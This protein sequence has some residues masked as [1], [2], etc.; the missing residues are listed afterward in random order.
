LPRKRRFTTEIQQANFLAAF[1]LVPNVRL[2]AKAANI[3]PYAHYDWMQ[4]YPDYKQKW[5]E[6]V[7]DLAQALEDE[8]IRRAKDG[9]KRML[10]Y[11]G[12]PIKTGRGKSARTAYET[13]Y[14]DQ[15]L[16]ALLK[17]FRPA[18]YREHTSVD[19]TG[20]IDL[21]ERMQA[22][23]RRVVEMQKNDAGPGP[24]AATG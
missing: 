17:R 19:V 2:A 10:W 7:E 23:R 6:Q 13:E 3:P 18:L 4:R 21:V 9:V 24:D 14:S 5:Q 1:Q 15:L 22:A 8:A 11:K 16:I 20:S 12:K